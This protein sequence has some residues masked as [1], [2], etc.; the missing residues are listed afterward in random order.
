MKNSVI[1]LALIATHFG[2]Y[3]LGRQREDVSVVSTAS[4]PAHDN[5]LAQAER[6][7]SPVARPSRDIH[8]N[9]GKRLRAMASRARQLDAT[10]VLAEL[11]R[12]RYRPIDSDTLLNQQ[13]LLARY[14]E[15]DPETALS[16]VD[17]LSGMEYDF[18]LRK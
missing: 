14:A 13:L 1:V 18:A 15:L 8:E 16:Y 9:L 6:I 2:S 11:K 4:T 12:S 10:D 5:L 17:T 3:F 7:V